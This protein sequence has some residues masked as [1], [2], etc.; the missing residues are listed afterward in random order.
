MSPATPTIPPPAPHDLSSSLRRNIQTLEERRRQEAASA[1]R[2]ERIAD[3]ITSFTGSMTFVYLHLVLFGA[4]IVAN[5]GVIPSLPKFDPSF[6]ILAMVASVEAIFLST[7]VLISQNRMTAASAKR[8]D[9]DLH[10]SLLT[11]H[12]LTKLA[13]IVAAIANRLKIGT[14]ADPALEEIKKD[15]APEAVLDEIEAEQEAGERARST[16]SG[17]AGHRP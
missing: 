9:L 17:A 10:I 16:V 5:L 1:T 2:E 11:E 8:A 15:V 14:E 13:G 12:E 6:V 3:A 4:W 7:F